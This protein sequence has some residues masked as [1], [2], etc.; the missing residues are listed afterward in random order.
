MLSLS[1]TDV[2][3]HS[4][5]GAGD[6][7]R[8]EQRLPP[9]LLTAVKPPPSDREGGDQDQHGPRPSPPHHLLGLTPS[10]CKV[11]WSDDVLLERW[12]IVS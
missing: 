4:A 12:S 9:H 2:N 10:N 6:T 3:Y 5:T 7:L 11:R 8:V 1:L